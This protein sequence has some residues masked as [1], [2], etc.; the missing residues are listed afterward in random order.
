MQ[1]GS[2]SA[3]G[4]SLYDSPSHAAGA[5]SEAESCAGQSLPA[6]ADSGEASKL[7]FDLY[8]PRYRSCGVWT[9]QQLGH[10]LA[11]AE[12]AW[13]RSSELHPLMYSM[14]LTAAHTTGLAGAPLGASSAGGA[15]Q[16]T[17]SLDSIAGLLK[18]A[19]QSRLGDAAFASCWDGTRMMHVVRRALRPG[20]TESAAA[21]ATSRDARADAGSNVGEKRSRPDECDAGA[22]GASAGSHSTWGGD[23]RPASSSEPAT[24]PA[25]GVHM[26]IVLPR[27]AV[28]RYTGAALYN[29]LELQPDAQIQEIY[30]C[31]KVRRR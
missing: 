4:Q 3:T 19:I 5:A 13:W 15:P 23:A 8:L 9:V 1:H 25:A 11:Q 2:D 24:G 28:A 21:T 31:G 17:A 26:P 16:A 10:E 6:S 20:Y 29:A 14:Q 27:S 30:K 7:A 12:L 22:G 18:A